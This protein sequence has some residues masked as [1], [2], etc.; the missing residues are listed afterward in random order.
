VTLCEI[1]PATL[2]TGMSLALKIFLKSSIVQIAAIPPVKLKKS[3]DRLPVI[4][5]ASSTRAIITKKASPGLDSFLYN[6]NSVTI[7]A[8]PNFI[9]GT[10]DKGG[11]CISTT[12][13][14]SETAVN[15]ANIIIF[16]ELI[17]LIFLIFLIMSVGYRIK[18]ESRFT[19]DN[20]DFYTVGYTDYRDYTV[21]ESCIYTSFIGAGCISHSY[22]TI[23]DFNFVRIADFYERI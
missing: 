21:D 17:F 3:A 11:I 18:I 13:N 1:A 9:P 6:M 4:R 14:T 8:N 10:G 7:L 12:N 16:F 5:L 23:T 2:V 22:F 15:N 19:I 20:A